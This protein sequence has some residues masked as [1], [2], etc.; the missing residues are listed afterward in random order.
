MKLVAVL[1]S[2]DCR[3][4]LMLRVIYTLHLCNLNQYQV[5]VHGLCRCKC[6]FVLFGICCV[7]VIYIFIPFPR[8]VSIL[9]RFVFKQVRQWGYSHMPILH[10][11]H[12]QYPNTRAGRFV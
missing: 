7:N 1:F 10:N 2:Q 12:N 9:L 11:A 3:V 5:G 4:C 6:R 8:L